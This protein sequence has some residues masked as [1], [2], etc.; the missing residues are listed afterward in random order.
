M[1]RV[2]TK[3]DKKTKTKDPVEIVANTNYLNLAIFIQVLKLDFGFGEKRLKRAMESYLAL[4]QEVADKR[5][6][7]NGAIRNA[8][9]ITGIDSRAFIDYVLNNQYDAWRRELGVK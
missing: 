1:K 8:K 5:T 7:V 9:A 4:M 3:P 2:N 6:T